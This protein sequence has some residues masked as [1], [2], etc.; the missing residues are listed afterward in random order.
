[1][2]LDYVR[3]KDVSEEQVKYLL[4]M[5]EMPQI[6][7]FISIDRERYFSYVTQTPNVCFFSV[8][9]EGVLVAS[10]HLEICQKKCFVSL[11]VIPSSQRKGIGIAIL[12]KLQENCFV[13]NAISRRAEKF[14]LFKSE[15]RIGAF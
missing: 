12:R 2:T 5:Y 1:M 4:S 9:F 10:V 14:F 3:L 8:Y 7:R 15:N 13:T 11:A 6:S